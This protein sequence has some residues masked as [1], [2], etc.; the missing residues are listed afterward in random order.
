M[1]ISVTDMGCVVW[2]K[3]PSL[4]Q[5]LLDEFYTKGRLLADFCNKI[6]IRP[7]LTLQRHHSSLAQFSSVLAVFYF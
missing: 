4:N 6:F 3:T 5:N 2:A 1:A 7:F